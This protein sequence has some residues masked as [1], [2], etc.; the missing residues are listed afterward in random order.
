MIKSV[1]TLLEK[2]E[3][4]QNICVTVRLSKPSAETLFTKCEPA[5]KVNYWFQIF[6]S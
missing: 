3:Q 2:P 5:D 6:S 1:K 4:L